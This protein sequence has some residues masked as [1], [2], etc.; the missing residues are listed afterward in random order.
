MTGNEGKSA[1]RIQALL[2]ERL[3]VMQWLDK[4]NAAPDDIPSDVRDRVRGDYQTR[5]DGVAE[6]L[7]T[8]SSELQSNLLKLQHG[9]DALSEKEKAADARLAEAKLR[10]AVG[11]FGED[12]WTKLNDEI[13]NELLSV[14][15]QITEADGEISRL[16]EVLAL[17]KQ[18]PPSTQIRQALPMVEPPPPPPP[19]PSAPPA[20]VSHGQADDLAFINPAGAPVG[21]PRESLGVTHGP[22]PPESPPPPAPRPEPAAAAPPAE[23]G[24]PK[25]TLKCG[26]CGVMNFPTEWYCERCGAE[27]AAL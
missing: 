15:S 4:L 27:L 24:G 14:R 16:E 25:K 19:A 20:T 23:G 13:S 10:H 17:I 5:L 21:S 8:Y 9:R 18:K 3:K 11:E 22:P 7:Q 1:D 12:Q 26:E 6:E 2:D